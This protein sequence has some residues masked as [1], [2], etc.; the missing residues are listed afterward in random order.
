VKRKT[1]QSEQESSA[2][3]T[4]P[5]KQRLE[6]SAAAEFK[7]QPQQVNE[8]VIPASVTSPPKSRLP[9]HIAIP[10][11]QKS[12]PSAPASQQAKPKSANKP[13]PT[14]APA[15]APAPTPAP[16]PLPQVPL[17]SSST[18]TGGAPKNMASN[19]VDHRQNIKGGANRMKEVIADVPKRLQ[20]VPE[21]DVTKARSGVVTVLDSKPKG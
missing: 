4:P 10:T 8:T 9:P 5:K 12:A 17:S 7:K 1:V 19:K 11:K 13:T 20:Q 18:A 2:P 21:L 3:L 16:A 14:P 6:K 15:P